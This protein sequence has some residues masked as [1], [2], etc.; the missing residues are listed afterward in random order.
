MR[1]PARLL[2]T[3]ALAA[4]AAAAP[5]DGRVEIRANSAR[6]DD[7]T[8]T[9][10]FIGDVTAEGADVRLSAERLEVEGE[11]SSPVYEAAGSPA[12]LG[13]TMRDGRI[14]HAQGTRISLD[15]SSR[16]MTVSGGSLRLENGRIVADRIRFLAGDSSL[17]AAGGVRFVQ[18][19]LDIQGDRMVAS[20]IGG[21]GGADIEVVGSPTTVTGTEGNAGFAATALTLR[22]GGKEDGIRLTGDAK[23]RNSDGEIA[24][25]TIIYN[26]DDNTFVAVAGKQERVLMIMGGP[27]P[28]EEPSPGADAGPGE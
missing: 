2:A 12:K 5:A 8:K 14:V 9:F 15:L 7:D 20:S 16:S 1:L 11:E 24:G 27:D 28:D 21:E 3:L 10:L 6:Y 19:S 26:P 4:T 23:A 17:D 22:F 13:L 25:E 18:E